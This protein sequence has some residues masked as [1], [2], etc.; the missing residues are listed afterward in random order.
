MKLDPDWKRAWRW[1]SVQAMTLATALIGAW[2]A[3]PEDWRAIVPEGVAHAAAVVTLLLGIVG[4]V[5]VQD[6]PPEDKP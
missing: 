1:Y 5:V 4:R 6:P 2:V 3:M